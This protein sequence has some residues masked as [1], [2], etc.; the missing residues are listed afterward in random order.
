ML[1]SIADVSL[2]KLGMKELLK[3]TVGVLES[4]DLVRENRTGGN[5]ISAES[6]VSYNGTLAF[7]VFEK[8]MGVIKMKLR[9]FGGGVIECNFADKFFSP[10]EVVFFFYSSFMTKYEFNRGGLMQCV[11]RKYVEEL[12]KQFKVIG[13]ESYKDVVVLLGAVKLQEK[14]LKFYET[15][16]LSVKRHAPKLKGESLE[17]VRGY[18]PISV[19]KLTYNNKYCGVRLVTR[20]GTGDTIAYDISKDKISDAELNRLAV[21]AD[22]PLHEHNGEYL[23]DIEIEGQLKCRDIS[24]SPDMIKYLLSFCF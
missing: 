5:A 17:I 8:S 24:D 20:F 19:F 14:M 4:F 3:V 7:I 21:F 11:L 1:K 6:E 16:L 23:S 18:I 12:V 9:N 22:I 10:L 15:S 2:D 13:A